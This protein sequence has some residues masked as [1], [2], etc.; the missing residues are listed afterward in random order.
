MWT[1]EK[2]LRFEAAH[3]LPSHDGKCRRLHG[4]SF[5]AIVR[6]AGNSVVDSPGHPEHG[7]VIDFGRVKS[8]LT[9]FVDEF[10]DHQHLNLTTGLVSPTSENLA[11]WIFQRVTELLEGQLPADAWLD[12]VT[13]EETCTARA[14]Y[15]PVGG[16]I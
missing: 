15:S 11:W 5:V 3:R 6:V 9:Q 7:M 16:G 14:T 2:D 10:L 4:H 1:I 13:V 12:S 8:V